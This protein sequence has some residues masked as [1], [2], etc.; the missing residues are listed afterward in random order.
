M[1]QAFFTS[2]TE[3]QPSFYI[4]YIIILGKRRSRRRKLFVRKWQWR[5]K[6][7]TQ[8]SRTKVPG[9]NCLMFTSIDLLCFTAQKSFLSS[10][11][12]PCS[13]LVDESVT[14]AKVH[15]CMSVPNTKLRSGRSVRVFVQGGAKVSRCRSRRGSEGRHGPRAV[16][17][18]RGSTGLAHK[19][20]M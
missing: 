17:S 7:S 12:C 20:A 9:K 8:Q 14:V 2:H 5:Q 1:P 4:V 13:S 10:L 11:F 15:F 3:H 16:K 19:D 6:V 18:K